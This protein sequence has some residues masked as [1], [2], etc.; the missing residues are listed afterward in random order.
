M[1]SDKCTLNE[2]K[3][4]YANGENITQL[5]M[6]QSNGNLNSLD[7]IKIAYD[8]QSGDYVR[9]YMKDN[10]YHQAISELMH[11]VIVSSFK[12]FSSILDI[13]CGE[14]TNTMELFKYFKECTDLHAIDCSLSRLIVGRNFINKNASL[15]ISL[16]AADISSLPY[17]DDSIDVIVSQHAL[18]PNRGKEKQIIEELL[19]VSRLGLVLQEPDYENSTEFQKNR[20]DSL[21]YVRGIRRVL[22][23]YDVDFRVIPVDFH[24]NKNNMSS[25]F[26]VNKRPNMNRTTGSAS[27]VEPYSKFILEKNEN[28]YFSKESGL[29]YPIVKGIPCFDS[30]TAIL[31]SKFPE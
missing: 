19:R 25:L 12:S 6:Q 3:K 13:G 18:E 4:L 11:E 14:L 23:D 8:F 28:F 30:S 29:L 7:A 24:V 31:C 17:G 15:K 1:K 5:L 22:S 10:T 16:S 20:M 2:L 26:I 21:G 27:Y 9:A